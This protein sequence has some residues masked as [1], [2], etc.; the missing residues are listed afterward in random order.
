MA[1]ADA[2]PACWAYLKPEAT[3]GW[4]MFFP[5]GEGWLIWL[6]GECPTDCPDPSLFGGG[7]DGVIGIPP[8]QLQDVLRPDPPDAGRAVDAE[9]E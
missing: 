6:R 7:T 2:S 9:R 8:K 4:L 3:V 1:A 5:L